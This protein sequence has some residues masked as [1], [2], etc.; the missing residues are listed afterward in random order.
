MSAALWFCAGGV[1]SHVLAI[2]VAIGF[3]RGTGGV[4]SVPP[5]GARPRSLGASRKPSAPFAW[6]ALVDIIARLPAA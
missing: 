4:T 2:A 1:A 6:L 3:A 5:Y